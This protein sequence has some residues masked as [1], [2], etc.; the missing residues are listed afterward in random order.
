MRNK[1][2]AF[3]PVQMPSVLPFA[4]IA[5]RSDAAPPF[6][7][8]A[9]KNFPAEQN[10]SSGSAPQKKETLS[11]YAVDD[12]PALTELYTDLLEATGYRVRAFNNRVD[13]LAALT[14]E[15]KMPDLLIVDYRGHSMPIEQFI[16]LCRAVHPTL[17]VLMATGL[18][19]ANVRFSDVKPDRFIQKP[20][21]PQELLQEV[22]ASFAA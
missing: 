1:L 14:M 18:D 21:T 9:L 7:Q 13:A 12:M 19:K 8:P 20:F 2:S 15:S 11:I 5:P 10:A 16:S 17:R 3:T 6:W 4:F 22:K